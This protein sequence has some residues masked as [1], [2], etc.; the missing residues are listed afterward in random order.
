[1]G[2]GASSV[3][4]TPNLQAGNPSQDVS[5]PAMAKPVS[6]FNLNLEYELER[7]FVFPLTACAVQLVKGSVDPWGIQP[8]HS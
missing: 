6:N 7:S 2:C 8:L 4:S 1:M 3:K 5:P